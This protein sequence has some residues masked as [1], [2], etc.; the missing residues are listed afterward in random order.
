MKFLKFMAAFAVFCFFTTQSHAQ[1]IADLAYDAANNYGI[2][3]PGLA[4]K[5]RTNNDASV[6]NLAHGVQNVSSS[7]VALNCA[8]PT[9]MG[10]TSGLNSNNARFQAQ[11]HVGWTR[12]PGTSTGAANASFCVIY[13]SA[14]NDE[15]QN[16]NF[17]G[18]VVGTVRPSFSGAMSDAEYSGGNV[19][20]SGVVF[21]EADVAS[22]SIDGSLLSAFCVLP[23]GVRLQALQYDPD[24]VVDFDTGL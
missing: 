6:I 13:M 4:C 11:Y 20:D 8:W 15:N 3:I 14:P 12:L 23:G 17:E 10:N 16:P 9:Q 24:S 19:S 2:T 7:D 22:G 21:P 5:T 18:V 1:T